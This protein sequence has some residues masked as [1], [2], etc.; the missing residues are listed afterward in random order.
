MTDKSYTHIIMILDRS[1]SMQ[2][3]TD[4]V[5][6]EV[7]RFI[8]DQRKLPGTC[9]LSMIT[10]DDTYE[11]TR[12]FANIK[13]TR[14]IDKKDYVP[15]GTTALYK[16]IVDVTRI[17]G[18]ALSRMREESRPGKVIVCI[19]SDGEENSSNARSNHSTGWDSNFTKYYG[20]PATNV[21]AVNVPYTA[22]LVRE[23]VERQINHYN[24]AFLY[25]GTDQDTMLNAKSMGIPA[26]TTVSYANTSEGLSTAYGT[27]NC[28]VTSCR[29]DPSSAISTS[30]VPL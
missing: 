19:F 1:G 22:S 20:V 11:Y 13:D 29:V 10:F 28:A 21:I 3:R 2:R 4:D 5:I 30:Q 18:A 9:T 12:N 15:R 24:W 27:L 23:E 26:S 16:T 14:L 6:R 25:F 8:E 7:N 17:E